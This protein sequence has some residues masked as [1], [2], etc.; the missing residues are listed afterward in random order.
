MADGSIAMAEPFSPRELGRKI[1]ARLRQHVTRSLADIVARLE[2]LQ[3]SIEATQRDVEATPTLEIM[4]GEIDAAIAARLSEQQQESAPPL[5]VEDFRPMLE[6]MAGKWQLEWERSANTLVHRFL[7]QIRQPEDGED[8]KDGGS[9]EDFDI[10]IDGR[11]LTV[12]MKIGDRIERR[13]VR[14]DIPIYRD[15]YQSG[16]EYERGDMVTFA[17]SVFIA[18][19]D[20]TA[21]EKPEASEAWKL[22]VKRGRDGKDGEGDQ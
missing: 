1:L 3:R 11:N 22:A 15:V 17:G 16:K 10:A 14:L 7:D 2:S 13:T 18:K 6:G 21:K 12:T 5:T 19:R 4:R 20:V 8:G 9:I